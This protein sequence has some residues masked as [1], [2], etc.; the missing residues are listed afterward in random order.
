MNR[1]T[2]HCLQSYVTPVH[3]RMWID[4]VNTFVALPLDVMHFLLASV[5]STTKS[6]F[7]FIYKSR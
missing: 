1:L 5:I 3:V 2:L 7:F 4:L 6:D